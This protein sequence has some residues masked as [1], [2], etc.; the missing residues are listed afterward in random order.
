MTDTA[1][2]LLDALRALTRCPRCGGDGEESVGVTCTACRGSGID[3]ANPLNP[4]LPSLKRL[5]DGLEAALGLRKGKVDRLE[6]FPLMV[7]V[8]LPNPDEDPVSLEAEVKHWR[9]QGI[10]PAAFFAALRKLQEEALVLFVP[11][12]LPAMPK[13][14]HVKKTITFDSEKK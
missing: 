6:A 1:H 11:K 14:L 9:V 10:E 12:E 5:T 2:D 7:L 13:Q 3:P 8:R 4:P